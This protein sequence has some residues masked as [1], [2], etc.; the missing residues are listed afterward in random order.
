M[1]RQNTLINSEDQKLLVSKVSLIVAVFFASIAGYAYFAFIPHFLSS[2]GFNEGE[3]IFI[4]LWMGI[5]MA[6]FSWIFGRI[7]DK[8]GGRK[9]FFFLALLL[10]VIV[11]SLLNLSNHI[12]FFCILNFF[13][14]FVLGMRM[15]ASN[16]LFADIVEKSNKKDEVKMN[17]E[18]VEVSG[19]QLSLYSASKSTG[20][21]IGVLLS[22]S[23]INI[24]GVD[25][26]VLFLIITT[27]ISLI[28]AIPIRDIKK[29]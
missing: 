25:S 12:V 20:F 19:T 1:K 23:L 11:L 2:K 15:P 7:S 21:A 14:G 16:A 28:F 8:S 4:M 26:L 3:V 13:R 6:I 29:N 24:F 5:G 22:S 17:L 27:T 9:I 10:Q 18:T